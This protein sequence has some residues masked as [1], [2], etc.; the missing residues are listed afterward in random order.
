MLYKL[1][2]F[3][4]FLLGMAFVRQATAQSK[5]DIQSYN[6]IDTVGPYRS[7][8]HLV[9]LS[10][11]TK[12]VASSG[13]DNN[14]VIWRVDSNTVFRT[15]KGHKGRVND[16]EYTGDGKYLA[17]ASADGTVIIW[18]INK[19]KSIRSYVPEGTGGAKGKSINFVCFSK[20]DK[21]ILF[22][23]ENNNITKVHTPL[24]GGSINQIA[25]TAES[26][27]TGVMSPDRK[28]FAFSSGALIYLM[29]M[30]NSDLKVIAG[31]SDQVTSLAFSPDNKYLASKCK[32][33]YIE[34]WN[35]RTSVKAKS[36]KPEYDERAADFSKIQYSPDGKYFC[37]GSLDDSPQMWDM[38]DYKMLYRL[39]GHA[40]P[41]PEI[42]FSRD[43]RLI[44]SASQDSTIRIWY[45]A[46]AVLLAE[47][48]KKFANDSLTKARRAKNGL[49][50]STKL[51]SEL[52]YTSNSS[53]PLTLN[54]RKVNAS[55]PVEVMSKNVSL[56]VWDD[57]QVDGDIISLNFNGQW[58]LNAYKLT[59]KKK[60]VNIILNENG[61][62]FLL[63]YAHNEGDTPPNTAGVSIY[64]GYRETRL[65]LKSDLKSCDAVRLKL[66]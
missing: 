50:D 17:S 53:I 6:V 23:G 48:Q 59:K 54:G 65:I 49:T 9:A 5:F 64:D 66:K 36:I 55:H 13:E 39:K 44:A 19:N 21:D 57:D 56:Y 62:N 3:F 4:F 51:E 40:G 12:Y 46:E 16:I 30:A 34:F 25:S 15:L 41:T 37:T 10:P 1:R 7:A 20:D 58:V 26:V 2:V 32:D 22:G 63:L 61:D 31:S 33:R 14:I 35:L 47:E 43:G 24:I 42:E 11:D 27:S 8:L 45:L 28:W 29:N 38:D 18:D 52:T 60:V